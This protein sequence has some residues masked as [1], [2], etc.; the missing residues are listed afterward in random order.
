MSKVTVAFGSMIIGLSLGWLFFGSH[1][2]TFAQAPTPSPAAPTAPAPCVGAPSPLTN[3]VQAFTAGNFV[4][5]VPG[6]NPASGGFRKFHIT[7]GAQQIDGLDVSDWEFENSIVAYGGGA[8]KLSPATFKGNI[9]IVLTGAAANTMAFVN[10]LTSAK[11]PAPPN[12]NVPIERLVTLSSPMTDVT[13]VAP[14]T[15]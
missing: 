1:T 3:V 2:V 10:L 13:F 9:R 8:V 5:P 14:Y 12:P 15:K 11:R 6:L 4:P 7:N